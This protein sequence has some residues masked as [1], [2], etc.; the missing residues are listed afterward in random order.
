MRKRRV[1]L[2]VLVVVVVALL[3]AVFSREREREPA[4]GGDRLSQW[5]KEYAVTSPNQPDYSLRMRKEEAANAISHIGTNAL[6]HLLKWIRYESPLWKRKLCDR[7]NR[8][9]AKVH[10][11]WVISDDQQDQAR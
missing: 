10:L 7:L 1:Y 9:L 8:T 6:P 2:S 11:H 4:Y 3:V 5:V